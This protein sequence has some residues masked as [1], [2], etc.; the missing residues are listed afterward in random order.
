VLNFQDTLADFIAQL[1]YPGASR[2]A[3]ANH[4]H[5]THIPFSYVPVYHKIKFTRSGDSN[6]KK[7]EIVDA[8]FVQPEQKTKHGWI[9][10]ACFDTVLVQSTKGETLW[11]V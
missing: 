3:L 11:V 8:V 10:P 9:I 5:N 1:N 6:L 2:A 7:P 4:A